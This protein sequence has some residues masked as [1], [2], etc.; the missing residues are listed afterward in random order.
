MEE[1][2][3]L[4]LIGE[5]KLKEVTQELIGHILGKKK[6]AGNT[7][8]DLLLWRL[9]I[10][11]PISLLRKSNSNP[12]QLR[13]LIDEGITTL[14]IRILPNL[15]IGKRI[16][17]FLFSKFYILT[18]LENVE[19]DNCDDAMIYRILIWIGDLYRYK[20][21]KEVSLSFYKEAYHYNT[22]DGHAPNQI[23]VVLTSILFSDCTII[24]DCDANI[25]TKYE[26]L[27]WYI[28]AI[29]SKNEP[30]ALAIN[31]LT[32]FLKKVKAGNSFFELLLHILQHDRIIKGIPDNFSLQE[33]KI[34]MAILSL[35]PSVGCDWLK[36]NYDNN[37]LKEFKRFHPSIVTSNPT[38]STSTTTTS[39]CQIPI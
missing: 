19:E 15:K 32:I 30:F 26:I 5:G 10:Y 7:G 27:H 20:E 9:I 18:H 35:N 21:D 14:L 33:K 38:T 29:F 3:I 34:L 1:R 16:Q 25:S 17:E 4:T 39:S 37:L 22:F 31:N 12:I 6:D 8:I 13:L 36:K 28:E 11:E 2:R 23:A 24:K